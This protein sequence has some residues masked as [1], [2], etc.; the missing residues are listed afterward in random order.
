MNIH[1]K[2][3]IE[4]LSPLSFGWDYVK[5]KNQFRV[6]KLLRNRA[7]ENPRRDIACL[8]VSTGDKNKYSVYAATLSVYDKLGPTAMPMNSLRSFVNDGTIMR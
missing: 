8:R 6:E 7:R 1:S 5:L 2:E 4:A 3:R